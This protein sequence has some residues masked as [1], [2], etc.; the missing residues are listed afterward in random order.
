MA[1]ALRYFGW[2]RSLNNLVSY[3]EM[4]S[5]NV[6]VLGMMYLNADIQISFSCGVGASS[7]YFLWVVSR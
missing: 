5:Y 6:L 4:I 7:T 3:E 2:L 1:S